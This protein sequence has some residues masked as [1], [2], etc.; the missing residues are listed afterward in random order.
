MYIL[1]FIMT[2]FIIGYLFNIT[3]ISNSSWIVPISDISLA[4]GLYGSV[5]GIDLHKLNQ[6]ILVV[7]HA[8]TVGV[9]LK[10]SIIGGVLWLYMDSPLAFLL[11]SI[12]AQIDPLSTSALEKNKNLSKDGETILRAWSSFDDPITIMISLWLAMFLYIDSAPNF[13]EVILNSALTFYLNVFMAVIVYFLWKYLRPLNRKFTCFSLLAIS[14]FLAI[15]YELFLGLAII[16]L[17]VRPP[18]YG[19]EDKI[20][21]MTLIVVSVILG[22]LLSNGVNLIIGI[23]IGVLTLLSHAIVAFF[24]TENMPV[25]DRFKLSIAHQSGITAISLSLYFMQYDSSIIEYTSVAI[26]TINIGYIILN[27][28]TDNFVIP[29]YD[30]KY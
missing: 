12:I 9:I 21:F 1:I 22:L 19:L 5:Y 11:A 20:I 16:A 15:Y 28:I 23:I 30:Q 14:F 2:G 24:L 13:S 6:N 25:H 17:F 18:L 26:I 27:W 7:F 3:D 10:I 8:I 4:I 29:L